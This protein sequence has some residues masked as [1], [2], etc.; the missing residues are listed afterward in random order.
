MATITIE[1]GRLHSD[2]RANTTLKDNG[3]AVD[4][5]GLP[6]RARG[7]ARGRAGSGN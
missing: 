2:I 3:V 7:P 5:N 1:P 6:G 4:W